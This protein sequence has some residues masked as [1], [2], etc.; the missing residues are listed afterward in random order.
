MKE[1]ADGEGGV[2][3]TPPRKTTFKKSRLNRVNQYLFDIIRS[4]LILNC[5]IWYLHVF[6]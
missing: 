4:L 2:K 6:D 5:L 3:L 1:G